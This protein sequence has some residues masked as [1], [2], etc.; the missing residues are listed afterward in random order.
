M[1][2]TRAG[3]QEEMMMKK[4]LP[5][6]LLGATGVWVGSMLIYWFNLDNK[7]IYFLVRPLLGRLYDRRKVDGKV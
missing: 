1:T 7:A 3:K 5:K 2:I 4:L 6:L